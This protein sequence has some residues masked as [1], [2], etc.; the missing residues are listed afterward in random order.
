MDEQVVLVDEKDLQV[1]TAGKTEVHIKGLLHRAVSVFIF[2]SRGEL[3]LQRR[4]MSKY[5]CGGLWSNT[6]CGHPMPGESPKAAAERRLQDEMNMK[7]QLIYINSFIYKAALGNGLIEHELD[8]VYYGVSD[9]SPD[10]NPL[11]ADD[12]KYLSPA[13]LKSELNANPQLYTPWLKICIDS[14]ILGELI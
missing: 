11:E 9:F 4:A 10:P 13:M 3:L 14:K 2:N 1:G 7:V 5:H 12:W 8:H 6:C